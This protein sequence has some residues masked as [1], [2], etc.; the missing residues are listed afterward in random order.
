MA[1]ADYV[2][3]D[4]VCMDL[5]PTKRDDAI[6]ALLGL[7][8]ACKALPKTRAKDA[9]KALIDREALGSTAIGN[10]VAVPHARLKGARGVSIAFGYSAQGVEFNALDGEPAHQVFVILAPPGAADEYIEVM[11]RITRLVQNAD[12]R[13]FVGQTDSAAAMIE[14]IEEMDP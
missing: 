11:G 2:K 8:V 4:A 10:G 5:A 3:A 7:L 13:R 9:L 14:L 1:L 12:F 6:A